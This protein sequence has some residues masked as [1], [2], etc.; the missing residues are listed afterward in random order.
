MTVLPKTLRKRIKKK[1]W[2]W[3]PILF[4][5]VIGSII[6]IIVSPSVYA[7]KQLSILRAKQPITK[8][9]MKLVSE[10][11]VNNIVLTNATQL[12]SI[13][14]AFK[15]VQEKELHNGGAFET[16][17]EV[18]IYKGNKKVNLF[19]QHSVY[20]GWMIVIG[21]KTLT[22]DYLFALV[23]RYSKK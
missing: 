12:D 9:E 2:L 10:A 16:W 8:V 19:I 15:K 3:R 20:N 22:S 6:F 21:S 17:A 23:R 13:S 1:L 7:N 11:G 14:N 4:F 5:S 18:N